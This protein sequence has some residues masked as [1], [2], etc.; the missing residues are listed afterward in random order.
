MF[1]ERSEFSA[2]S[3]PQS[4]YI[5]VF[6]GTLKPDDMW[7]IERYNVK[8]DLWEIMNVKLPSNRFPF[9]DI[10][11]THC[12]LLCANNNNQKNNQKVSKV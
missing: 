2:V 4:H 1:I 6:G 9:F 5:Y 12:V 10:F 11:N 3:N 7:V 8:E